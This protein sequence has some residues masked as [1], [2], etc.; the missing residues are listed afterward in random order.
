MIKILKYA[1]LIIIILIL[2]MYCFNDIQHNNSII[3]DQ[4]KYDA[5]SAWNWIN[6][7]MSKPLP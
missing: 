3:T 4:I 1:G 6:T 2:G 5:I 7:A